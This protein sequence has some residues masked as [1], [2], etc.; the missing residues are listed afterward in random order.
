MPTTLHIPEL[1]K[2]NKILD[3]IML[4]DVNGLVA[5][6]STDSVECPSNYFV[7]MKTKRISVRQQ[8]IPQSTSAH[9]KKI[10]TLLHHSKVPFVSSGKIFFTYSSLNVSTP[11]SLFLW[12]LFVYVKPAQLNKINLNPYKLLLCRLYGCRFI[13]TYSRINQKRLAA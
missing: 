10:S 12:L 2:R 4:F 5:T 13:K 9:T 6:D 7:A 11:F 1:K 8:S 3:S